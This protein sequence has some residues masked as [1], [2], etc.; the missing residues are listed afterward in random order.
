MGAALEG[1]AWRRRRNDKGERTA[2]VNFTLKLG[3][4]DQKPR[5]E[6]VKEVGK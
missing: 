3:D 6:C 5:G 4:K 1:G 2:A